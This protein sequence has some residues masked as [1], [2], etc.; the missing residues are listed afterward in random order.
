MLQT[1]SCQGALKLLEQDPEVQL[2]D[3]RPKEDL[4]ET[5]SPDLRSV[6]KSPINVAYKPRVEVS[7]E[8]SQQ[9]TITIGWAERLCRNS[10]V[11]PIATFLLT[12]FPHRTTAAL[13]CLQHPLSPRFPCT[14]YLEI[15]Q[16]NVFFKTMT[17][18]TP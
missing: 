18:S 6:K 9:S 1:V 17:Q 3:I 14:V 8:G 7:Q 10:K 11:R 13:P 15:P 4:R 2:I 12:S 16:Q 5:G